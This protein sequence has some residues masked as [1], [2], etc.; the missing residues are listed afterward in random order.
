MKWELYEQGVRLAQSICHDED[1]ARDVALQALEEDAAITK[2]GY[3]AAHYFQ[4]VKSRTIDALRRTREHVGIFDEAE[5]VSTTPTPEEQLTTARE[6]DSIAAVVGDTA[7]GL[8]LWTELLGVDGA[9]AAYGIDKRRV[10][11]YN[12]RSRKILKGAQ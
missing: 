10:S 4:R 3:G 9:A 12:S 6:L 1:M 8:L 7:A 2:A 11:E 5:L